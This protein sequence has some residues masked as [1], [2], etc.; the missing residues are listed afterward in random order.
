M[1]GARDGEHLSI[2]MERPRSPRRDPAARIET[3]NTKYKKIHNRL[4]GRLTKRSTIDPPR[5]RAPFAESAR[6]RRRGRSDAH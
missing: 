6:P 1:F 4:I 5:V 3:S 2:R